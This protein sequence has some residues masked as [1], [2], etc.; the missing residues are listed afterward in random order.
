M[1]PAMPSQF[2]AWPDPV[3]GFVE[4]PD[5]K[6][7]A[8]DRAINQL[9]IKPIKTDKYPKHENVVRILFYD[10]TRAVE[11]VSKSDYKKIQDLYLQTISKSEGKQPGMLDSELGKEPRVELGGDTAAKG[12]QP[13]NPKQQTE[14]P[15]RK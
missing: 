7:A 10:N 12:K 11:Y 5:E 1:Q 9:G 13:P 14:P 3:I 6:I 4:V 2:P 15:P 8:Y